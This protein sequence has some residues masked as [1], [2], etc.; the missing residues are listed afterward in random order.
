MN[1]YQSEQEIYSF[2]GD[3]QVE[4]GFST[5]SQDSYNEEAIGKSI[6]ETHMEVPLFECAL[7]IAIVGTGNKKLGNYRI[8][9][10][11][12]DIKTIFN[13][14]NVNYQ[15]APN[16]VLKENELT[17]NRLCRYFRHHIKKYIETNKCQTYLYRK[18]SNH[19]KDY[20]SICFRG[21]EYL[22]DLNSNQINFFN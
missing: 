13:K 17:P 15:S 9:N 1:K 10:N 12:I 5:M 8:N 20:F 21:A 3:L 7:N 2:I 4:E 19:N 16:S 22:D 14:A 18:Y 6:K 11:L